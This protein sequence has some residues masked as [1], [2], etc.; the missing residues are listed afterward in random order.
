LKIS[1]LEI[2]VCPVFSVRYAALTM[3]AEAAENKRVI[4]AEKERNGQ[5][6]IEMNPSATLGKVGTA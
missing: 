1:E 4:R 5:M 6:Q 2:G 3:S